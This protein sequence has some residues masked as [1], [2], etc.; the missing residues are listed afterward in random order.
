MRHTLQHY[1]L[2]KPDI[3]LYAIDYNLHNHALANC[4]LIGLD[5]RRCM[6]LCKGGDGRGQ[7]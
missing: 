6:L 2:T 3:Y 7:P 1:E 4:D 5:F